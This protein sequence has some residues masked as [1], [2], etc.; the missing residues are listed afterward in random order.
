MPST[1]RTPKVSCIAT[2][3][4]E[5]HIALGRIFGVH[6]QYADAARELKLA[7][8]AEP[9]NALAWGILSWA[10]AYQT[11]PDAVEAEKAARE[12][13]RLNSSIGYAQYHLGRALYMQN[14][15]PE[16]MAAFDRAPVL[17]SQP[18]VFRS[19]RFGDCLVLLSHRLV[20]SFLPF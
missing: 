17:C 16:A 2:S 18:L 19:N 10:L 4:P 14:R 15:F 9:E 7:V 3:S 12:A 6:Y 11:P 20:L 8:H 1:P 5:A 13:I